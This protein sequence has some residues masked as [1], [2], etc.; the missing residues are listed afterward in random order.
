MVYKIPY[1]VDYTNVRLLQSVKS[2]QLILNEKCLLE[3]RDGRT[4]TEL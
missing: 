4:L 2:S 3:S 1:I